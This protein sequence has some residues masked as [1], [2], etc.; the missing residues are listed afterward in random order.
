[1]GKSSAIH[2]TRKPHQTTKVSLD[3][4]VVSGPERQYPERQYLERQ[5]L[6][7]QYLEGEVIDD[8]YRLGRQIGQGGMG[9]VWVAH[10]LV[11]GV[12]VALKL[13]R[14]AQ[15]GPE[16][17]SR[18][19][20]EANAAA[21]V[22]H[23][24]LVRV[25]DFGW[26]S[27]GD[28]F[29]VMELIVGESLAD[30]IVRE[31]RIPAIRAVQTVL[32]IADG[33]RLAHERSI[34]HRDIKP[35]NI[36]ISEESPGRPQPKLL[37]FG[38]AKVGH[39]GDGKL[40]QQGVVLGSP[41]YMSPEQALGL[42]QIDAR[43]DVWSLGITL[44][45]LITGVVPFQRTNYNALMQA[46]IHDDPPLVSEH[47]GIDTA[48]WEVI[49][50]ALEKEP[51]QR[52]ASMSDFGTALAKWLYDH[53]IKEDAPGNSLR[54]VWLSE[55]DLVSGPPRSAWPAVGRSALLGVGE[56]APV[57]SST[58]AAP[59]TLFGRPSRARRRLLVALGSAGVLAV[60]VL[61]LW[62]AQSPPQVTAEAAT[63]E[64][65]SAKR[66]ADETAPAGSPGVS[67][68][69]EQPPVEDAPD[70]VGKKSVGAGNAT[71]VGN[72]A[73]VLRPVEPKRAPA[74]SRPRPVKKKA[75]RDFGF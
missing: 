74:R 35:G 15:T 45:E 29:L 9:V 23:P 46:I 58:V 63:S 31:K 49:R 64:L 41:E 67:T 44:Y 50:R 13:I 54:A 14:T 2:G 57:T 30:T 33:L 20:R 42:E 59:G 70:S 34:V 26:T 36:V 6:E 5:Y 43:T 53:G 47:D 32:P 37:D 11:L 48:L 52:W 40:T 72:D 8:R 51:S 60:A 21:R 10:S 1:M 71:T 24:S 62:L 68:P 22:T 17:A 73:P 39:G 75:N 61:V 19:A 38:I 7:R 4:D 27:H 18:M 65:S 3:A 25:F 55:V 12:D 28:P 56:L 66:E 16:G 69:E